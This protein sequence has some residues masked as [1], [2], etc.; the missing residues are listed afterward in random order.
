M[1]NMKSQISST[2]VFLVSGGAKGITA[3]CV[4]ELAK[5]K[6]CQFIL[7][8]R[9]AIADEP[10]WA[11]GCSSESELKQRLMEDF[12]AKGEKPTPV[13]VQHEFNAIS[14]KREIEKTLSAIEQAGGQAEYLSVDVTDLSALKSKLEAAVQRTGPVTGIIH[15][16]GNLAD[17]RIERKSERDFETVY[18]AKVKGLENLLSCVSP[19]QLDYLVLFSSVVG[20]YGNVGQSDYAIA[21]EILNKSAYLVKGNY[22][23]C[24]VAAINWGPWDSGMV[25]AELKKAFAERNI[26]TI[27]IDI[28]SQMLVDE[29]EPANQETVQV[30]IG[31]PLIFTPE[32]STSDLQAFQIHRRLTLAANPFLQD[33]VIAGNPVLPAT[34]SLSWIANTCEQLYPGYKFFSCANYKVLKGIIFD[35]NLVS[36]YILELKELAKSDA[37][38][39]EFDAKIWSKNQEGKIR[40]HYSTQL[41][42]MRQ[43]PVL[44]TY[45]SLNV[46]EDHPSPISSS[47]LYQSG[48]LS[49]FHGPSFQG[50]KKV[51]NINAEKITLE[52]FL[53]RVGERQQG[54]FP[55]QTCN[56]YIADVQVHSLWI[57][58]QHFF[59]TGCLPSEIKKVEQFAAIPFDETFYV[60]CEVKSKT[61]AA[62]VADVI[63][64]NLEGQIYSRML[65]AKGTILP[66]KSKRSSSRYAVEV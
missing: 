39:I 46:A 12:L 60:S 58:V 41:K 15:G 5:Q 7:L 9:S 26:E 1:L 4:I 30:L 54:Q 14:S 21:N 35:N 28:G 53:P 45:D 43:I 22:P 37:N 52:C 31:S 42:L 25:S 47:S 13:M 63:A 66:L 6:K 64:H 3:E 48:G 56:P 17:K 61:D 32:A 33:H 11:V 8:G 23:N 10:T 57:W 51:L 55:V 49:L 44:P 36:Q 38:E 62:V 29:L 19:S 18:N 50:V 27:P 16:A 20:F 59:E 2:S 65:G 24:R 34:C 40:Y